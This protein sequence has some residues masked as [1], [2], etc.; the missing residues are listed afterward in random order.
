VRR[1]A[2]ALVVLLAAA[3]CG[4][5]YRVDE[6]DAVRLA[7]AA[8]T[9]A[10]SRPP[11]TFPAQGSR[12]CRVAR[13]RAR[14]STRTRRAQDGAVVVTF[15]VAWPRGSHSWIYTV[16]PGDAGGPRGPAESGRALPR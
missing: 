10:P 16:P 3:G 9:H 1:L 15:V 4:S 5:K 14:C 12:A 7:Q 8:L 2:P 6:P 11:V 13:A